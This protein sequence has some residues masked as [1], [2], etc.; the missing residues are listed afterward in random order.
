MKL[1]WI[2]FFCFFASC[3]L[4]EVAF[5]LILRIHK[6]RYRNLWEKE[7]KKDTFWITYE[8]RLHGELG[9][10]TPYWIKQEKDAKFYLW[11]F[12]FLHLLTFLFWI[13]MVLA[14]YNVN[15]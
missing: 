10:K 8:R 1:S 9:W 12:R 15:Y 7:K 6:K 13:L 4:I 5:I 2:F 3:I 14:I 11:I